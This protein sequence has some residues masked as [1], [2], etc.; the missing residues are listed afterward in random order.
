MSH[1]SRRKFLLTASKGAAF[2]GTGF[3]TPAFTRCTAAPAYD[4]ILR[5]GIVYDGLGSPGRE[6]DVGIKGDRIAKIA[7]TLKGSK[8]T[9]EIDARGLAI[10]PGF[11]DMHT[12]T[13][14]SLVANPTADSHI[15]QGITTDISGNCGSSP[16]PLSNATREEYKKNASDRFGID[17][18]WED[19]KGFFWRLEENGMAINYATFV[20]HGDIRAKV[21]G[22]G[23]EKA[24]PGQIK[25]MQELV[26]QHIRE[27]AWGLSTGLE[28][29]P[30]SYAD[31]DELVQLCQVVAKNNGIHATHMRD[32]GDLLLEAIEEALHIAEETGVS[33]QIS[34]L[35]AAYP[36]NWDKIG[37][38][39]EKI[40]QATQR[41]MDVMADRYP[42]VAYSTGL[43]LFFPLWSREGATADF[44]ER[45]RNPELDQKL[46]KHYLEE[47][48]RVGSWA[49]V[50]ISSVATE[51]NRKFVGKDIQESARI[52]GK[53]TYEFMRDLLIEE[54]ARV[55]M[56]GFM[57]SEENLQQV[58][59]HPLVTIGSDGSAIAS[60]GDKNQ[61]KPHPRF[62]GT[63]P[64]VLGRYVREEQL[65][66]LPDAIRKMT[67]VP[68][69][70]MGISGRGELREGY[71]ADI[72]VFDPRR[73]IDRA[74]W[75]NP[76]QYPDGIPYVIVN[77]EVAVHEGEV[78]GKLPGRI[79]RKNSG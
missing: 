20:G 74:T 27:G 43:S 38:A 78:T 17:L 72:V 15:R 2:A 5:G 23:D 7:G 48:D 44:V 53:E 57:M 14:L 18:N 55:N 30:G 9:V 46:R 71:F 11:I 65:L 45:L 58:L 51:K 67:S 33:T 42:Y 29:S 10:S 28:Y 35:K 62:Y 21:V 73:I 32:E 59:S 60:R 34:H 37:T 16:F 19:M 76:H 68:A 39:L 77:G 52:S 1:I 40:E 64:R 13:D 47:T 3:I 69:R 66:S 36:R 54:E 4:M 25:A 50:R 75:D 31:T 22:L 24:T 12:H 63:M 61:D 79:L 26:E 56:V 41:G 49:N 6:I 70:K 8:Q